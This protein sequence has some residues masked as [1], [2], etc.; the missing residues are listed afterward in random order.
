VSIL[1]RPKMRVGDL[2]RT[3]IANRVADIGIIAGFDV[4]AD[5]IVLW[6]SG[7]YKGKK[8]AN[9]YYHVDII[10]NTE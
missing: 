5:P 8:E 9:F 3:N 2:V 4:D 7:D 6:L 1:L 10:S